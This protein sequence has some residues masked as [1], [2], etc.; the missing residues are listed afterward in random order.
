MAVAEH[1][2]VAA[3][4]VRQEVVEGP[5]LGCGPGAASV[6][7]PAGP[8]VGGELGAFVIGSAEDGEDAPVAQWK[9]KADTLVTA[10]TSWIST[11]ESA[12]VEGGLQTGVDGAPCA[13]HQR[14]GARADD[15]GRRCRGNRACFGVRRRPRGSQ[16]SRAHDSVADRH[17]ACL[18]YTSPS[19][20]D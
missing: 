16:L 17:R 1:E 9:E 10:F 3:V 19:P 20:R 7:G 12:L 15:A 5:G 11:A 13:H 6:G 14:H 4:G 8:F 2:G 18:L